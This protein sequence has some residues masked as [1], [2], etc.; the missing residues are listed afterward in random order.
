MKK[1]SSVRNS[2]KEVDISLEFSYNKDGLV[3][4]SGKGV[5]TMKGMSIKKILVIVGGICAALAF[6]TS[7]NLSTVMTIVAARNNAQNTGTTQIQ[8]VDE[9][10][11]PVAPPS[12]SSS[13]SSTPSG[14]SYTPA[15][16]SSSSSSST[17]SSSSS[18]SSSTPAS[19]P[20][21]SGKPAD[22]GSSGD[23]GQPAAPADN[24]PAS[25]AGATTDPAAAV[26]LY[27]DAVNK[28]KSSASSV[29]LVRDGALNYD[30]IFEAGALSSLAGPLRSFF[31]VEDKNDPKQP[32][33]L[34]PAGANCNLNAANV[35]SATV[36]DKDG[37]KEIVLVMNDATN[38][39]VGD[40]GV[41]SVAGIIQESQITDGVSSIPGIS[42]SNIKLDY[43][44]VKVT[45]TLDANGN[46]TYLAIDAPCIL[47]LGAKVAIMSIDNARVGIEVINEYQIAY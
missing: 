31:K 1:M 10:G 38:P 27:V 36:T 16:S 35:K 15:A 43:T 20:S 9:N 44:N 4:F 46:L 37:G 45:A 22:S 28:A 26:K 12:G 23:N 25:D 7:T 29:T 5:K 32:S 6:I 30:N 39:T 21:D 11:N 18:S 41:G 3:S 34:P 40:G 47:S 24:T 33:D 14:S 8:Y 13:S 19:T 2:R 42:L 17:P